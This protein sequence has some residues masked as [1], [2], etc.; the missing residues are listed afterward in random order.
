MPVDPELQALFPNLAKQFDNWDGQGPSDDGS[1]D[2]SH[3]GVTDE[4]IESYLRSTGSLRAPLSPLI[5]GQQP[6][7]V[8]E[9][10]N[11]GRAV[12]PGGTASVEP[13]QAPEEP[14]AAP[15]GEG[16]AAPAVEEP[17]PPP[18]P[19]FYN[20]RGK[21]YDRAQA[22]AWAQFDDMVSTD[23][24]LRDVISRHL[25]R[26]G[27]HSVSTPPEPEAPPFPELGPEY[28]DDE[29][30]K[31]MYAVLKAQQ[32]QLET[33]RQ[34]SAQ[35][36]QIASSQAQRTYEEIAQGVISE[37]QQKRGLDD[38]TMGKVSHAARSLGYV[39]QYMAGT[40]PLTGVPVKPDPY[41]AVRKALEAGYMLVPETRQLDIDRAAQEAA[42]RRVKELTRKEK[43]AGV[44]GAA[45]SVPR[46]QSVPS[47]PGDA[48]NAMIDEVRQ[49][50]TGSWA[51]D[52]SE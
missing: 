43:L 3:G 28:A 38:E 24:E 14:S 51:G 19:D 6:P 32:Q 5:S 27:G 1:N 12:P 49:M 20:I 33:V 44:S 50:F 9:F 41:M 37:F 11:N 21:R 29:T 36:Q 15:S 42:D 47:N 18:P 17:T 4:D 25:Q 40:D 39:N 31:T 26:R 13:P 35:A 34:Q 2:P 8:P 23:P 52:G 45:G 30:I 46:T 48:R 7:A 10:S 22:E 16:T